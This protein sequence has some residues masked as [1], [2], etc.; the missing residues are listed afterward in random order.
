MFD[1]ILVVMG[2]RGG[3]IV[4]W[5]DRGI[6]ADLFHLGD[7]WVTAGEIQVGECDLGCLQ[8]AGEWACVIFFGDGDFGGCDPIGPK[9]MGFLSL[10]YPFFG[11]TGISP[12]DR[13]VSIQLR[14]VALIQFFLSA[15]FFRLSSAAEK[16]HL[17]PTPGFHRNPLR[18]YGSLLRGDLGRALCIARPSHYIGSSGRL[19]FRTAPIGFSYDRDRT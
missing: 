3:C 12:F 5:W 2:K 14:P 11:N 7:E 18:H 8:T 4:G 10:R 15:G 17:H 9:R 19:D 13:V 16:A 1:V 6:D